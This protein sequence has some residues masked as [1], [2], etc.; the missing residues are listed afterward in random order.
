MKRTTKLYDGLYLGY[1]LT[2]EEAAKLSEKV[3]E[4]CEQTKKKLSEAY[5]Y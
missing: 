2:K 3:L 4:L 1:A 5:G